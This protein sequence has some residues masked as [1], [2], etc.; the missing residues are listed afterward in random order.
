MDFFDKNLRS[1]IEPSEEIKFYRATH[2]LPSKLIYS[3]FSHPDLPTKRRKRKI[4]EFPKL[5]PGTHLYCLEDKVVY[6]QGI[7]GAPATVIFLE[8]LIALGIKEIL[9]L[10]LVTVHIFLGRYRFLSPFIRHKTANLNQ[11]RRNR[12]SGRL[13]RGGT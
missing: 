8:E 13:K 12:K 4:R 9:F 7:L 3:P 6:F 1:Y 11:L 5:Y 10:G 2:P